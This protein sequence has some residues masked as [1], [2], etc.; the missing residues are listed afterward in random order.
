MQLTHTYIWSQLRCPEETLPGFQLTLQMGMFSQRSWLTSTMFCRCLWAFQ[1]SLGANSLSMPSNKS[2]YPFSYSHVGVY[3][4]ESIIVLWTEDTGYTR[5]LA[6][7][8]YLM[9]TVALRCPDLWSELHLW[10]NRVIKFPSMFFLKR[11]VL[12][13]SNSPCLSQTPILG[14]D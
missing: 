2:V 3:L 8:R 5:N 11:T 10:S 9:K 7:T 13:E 4:K 14:W 12:L 1:M 6:H